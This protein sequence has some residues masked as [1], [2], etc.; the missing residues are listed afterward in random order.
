MIEQRVRLMRSWTTIQEPQQQEDAYGEEFVPSPEP[1][2]TAV[3]VE[4]SPTS[5]SFLVD[6]S[7]SR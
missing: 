5:C 1:V 7:T 4:E 6:L 3:S 2:T